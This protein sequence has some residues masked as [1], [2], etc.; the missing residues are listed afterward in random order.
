MAD[1]FGRLAWDPGLDAETISDEWTRL[2]FGN[3]SQVRTTVN[4]LELN[5]WHIYES[6]TGPLGIGTLTDI[7]GSHFGPGI[8]SAERNGWGQW[9]RADHGGVG[10]DR[11]VATGT[12]FI[13][14]YPPELA[15][16]YESLATCPD[17]LLLFFHHVPYT[18]RLR[19]GKT[20]IQ[21][22]YDSHYEGAAAAA[23]YGDEWHKLRGL[24][25]PERYAETLRLLEY[26]TGH[27]I[28]WRDAVSE[29]FFRMSGPE[30]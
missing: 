18:Y 14:Q 4:K 7:L 15:A 29:W 3:D 17:A 6:Y 21:H 1:G 23:S 9:I 2:T 20:V 8:E 12:G 13:G 28:V 24:I 26:Q 10:M 11:T 19:S 22:I 25:D 16:Q 27:A 30:L 5:S